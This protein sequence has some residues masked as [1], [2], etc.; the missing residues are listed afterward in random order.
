MFEYLMPAIWMR[1]YRDT[2]MD[3]TL[4]ATVR[5]QQEYGRRNGIP[6]GISE[7][8]FRKRDAQGVYQYQAFGVPGLAL[9]PEAA[10]NLVVSPYSNFLALLVDPEGA[11]RNLEVMRRMGCLGSRGFY[12][13][14]DFTS[15]KEPD[16]EPNNEDYEII[17]CWMAHHQGMSLLA[18]SNLLNQ[19][20]IQKW[21]HREPQVKAVELLLHERVGLSV[22][23]KNGSTRSP[24]NGKRAARFRKLNPRVDF[25]SG[26]PDSMQRQETTPNAKR[27]S[28]SAE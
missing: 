17:R 24:K 9:D 25:S 14:C 10:E 6:W 13:S 4:S 19:F 1:S 2:L 21:F 7:A 11:T 18:L 8:A 27:E 15:A 16:K 28:S 20:S 12:E 22:A 26:R 5:C 3:Q 23:V